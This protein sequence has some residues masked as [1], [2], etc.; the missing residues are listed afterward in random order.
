[1]VTFGGK[2][3]VFTNGKWETYDD[4][5]TA[6]AVEAQSLYGKAV[7]NL[8]SGGRVVLVGR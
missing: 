4:H 7:E 2:F 6:V 8:R 5:A 1:M 3:R